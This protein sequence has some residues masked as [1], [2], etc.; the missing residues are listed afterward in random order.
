MVPGVCDTTPGKGQEDGYS[1]AQ[2]KDRT[3]PVERDPFLEKG[4]S[5]TRRMRERR[6]YGKKDG[7]S[8][9]GDTPKRK[10]N[11]RASEYVADWGRCVTYV[12]APCPKG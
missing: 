1:H 7:D 8:S 6:V 3:N 9:Q 10:V 2:R 11:L 12:E 4:L 5:L